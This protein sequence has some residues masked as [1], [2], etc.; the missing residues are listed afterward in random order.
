MNFVAN[1]Q[2]VIFFTGKKEEKK[3]NETSILGRVKKE[4]RSVNEVG[5]A[6]LLLQ[7]S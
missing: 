5:K 1:I 7:N 3:K 2:Q 4:D 6:G